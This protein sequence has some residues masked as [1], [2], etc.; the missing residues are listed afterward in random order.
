MEFIRLLY[1]HCYGSRFIWSIFKM[2]GFLVSNLWLM[3]Q[4]L[5]FCRFWREFLKALLFGIVLWTCNS[6]IYEREGLK[7]KK[8]LHFIIS[9]SVAHWHNF[10]FK[11]ISKKRFN[12]QNFGL[13]KFFCKSKSSL[14][15]SKIN[16]APIQTNLSVSKLFLNHSYWVM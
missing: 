2:R 7:N 8:S 16:E 3:E 1:S 13:Q 9:C 5:L 11:Y 12:S 10:S 14:A 15:I 6:F 4:K